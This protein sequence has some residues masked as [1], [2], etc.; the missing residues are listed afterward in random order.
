MTTAAVVAYHSQ[1]REARICYAGHPPVL[2]RCGSDKTW[3]FARQSNPPEKG[4]GRPVNIPLAVAPDT[5]YG[6]L[7]I[8]M[9]AGDRIFIYSDGLIDAPNLLGQSFGLV[10]LKDVLD[11]NVDA[12]LAALKYAVLRALH[13]HTK[14]PLS[15]D[16]VT[17]L[18]LE[19]R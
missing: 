9:T 7:T 17:I 10:R 14:G 3:S 11:A 18:V 13:Q 2:Y 16:D 12:P 4:N 6:Q 5:I 19:I 1:E 15:H 8:P